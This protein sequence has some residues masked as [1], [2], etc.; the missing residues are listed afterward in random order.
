MREKAYAPYS[1]FKVGAALIDSDGNIHVGCNIENASYGLT[2]CAERNAIS[3]W[4]LTTDSK[5]DAC[6]V[7]TD[8]KEPTPPCGACRQVLHEFNPNMQI[9]SRTLSGMEATYQLSELLP[10]AFSKE[11][12]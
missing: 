1:K 11:D 10:H 4:L 7:V 2:I 3:S 9:V 12:L 6:V 8:A 5:L